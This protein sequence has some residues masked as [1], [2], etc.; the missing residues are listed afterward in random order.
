MQRLREAEGHDLRHPQLPPAV[1]GHVEVDVHDGCR[2]T[3]QQD[4]VQVPVAQPQQIAELHSRYP[5]L[6]PKSRSRFRVLQ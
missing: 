3:V 4:I 5:I 2:P 1:K 6:E